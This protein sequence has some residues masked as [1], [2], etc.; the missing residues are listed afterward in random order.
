MATDAEIRARRRLQEKEREL[1]NKKQ[2]E[3]VEKYGPR[4]TTPTTTR[5]TTTSTTLPKR[6]GYKDPTF[7]S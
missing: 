4:T 3:A 6:R 1:F 7:N 2:K 5:Q